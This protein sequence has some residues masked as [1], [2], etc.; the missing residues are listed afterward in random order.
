MLAGHQG[1][2]A[3]IIYSGVGGVAGGVD[4]ILAENLEVAVHVQAAMCIA[5]AVDL[6][7]QR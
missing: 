2:V 5:L 7:G 6:L 1:V 3:L 4:G